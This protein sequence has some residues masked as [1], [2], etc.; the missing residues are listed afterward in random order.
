MAEN[1]HKELLPIS[2]KLFS[3]K[4]CLLL[5]ILVFEY[6]DTPDEPTV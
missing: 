4:V 5:L 2:G 6:I 1:G 3:S